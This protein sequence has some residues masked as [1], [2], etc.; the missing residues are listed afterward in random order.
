MTDLLQI[1]SSHAMAIQDDGEPDELIAGSAYSYL[2]PELAD[3]PASTAYA[4]GERKTHAA[5]RGLSRVMGNSVKPPKA[6]DIAP[7][8]TYFGQF[9]S[10]DISAT[11]PERNGVFRAFASGII[12]GI[13]DPVDIDSTDRPDKGKEV[14]KSIRNQH[15]RPLTLYSLYGTG[16]FGASAPIRSFFYEDSPTFKTAP[17]APLPGDVGTAIVN[18]AALVQVANG[19]DIPRSGGA[20]HLPLIVDRRNDDNLILSQL[21]LALMLFHNAAAATLSELPLHAKST[22]RKLFEAARKLVTWHYQWVVLHDFLPTL[23]HQG[24]VEAALRS[25]N[26]VPRPD[27]VPLEFSTAALRFGHSMV[28]AT[29][30]FN[31]NFGIGGTAGRLA[32]LGDMFQFTSRSKMGGSDL[33]QLPNHW[34]PDWKRL[35]KTRLGAEPVDS[36]LAAPMLTSLGSAHNLDHASIAYRNL[37]RSFHRRIAFGQDITRQLGL[38]PLPPAVIRDMIAIPDDNS[39]DREE[40]AAKTPAWFYFLCEAEAADGGKCVGPAASC[41]IAETII[42]LMTHNPD[43]LLN[44]G[45]NWTPDKSPLRTPAGKPVESIVGMLEFARLLR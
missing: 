16:P 30:D 32:S 7:I 29:Y 20:I 14:L 6:L 21:H 28:S 36:V 35:T 27:E 34:V 25:P 4:G 3:D 17:V 33:P 23:L 11:T 31:A 41:I 37:L 1:H 2:F 38:Q 18:V 42:G 22:P 45:R 8:Y 26:I 13:V 24:S 44:A 43:S 5:L 12:A 40:M 39:F 10:H 15:S 9:L 19:K